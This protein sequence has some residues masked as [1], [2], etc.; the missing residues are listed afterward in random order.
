MILRQFY[1]GCLSQASYLVADE[2]SGRAAVVDP[3][4]DVQEYLEAAGEHGLRIELVVLTHVHADFVPGHTELAERTGAEIAMGELAPVEFPVRRLRDGEVIT[5]GDPASGV[6]IEVLS[7]PGHTPES[8]TLAVR[9]RASDAAPSALLTGDTLF[10]GDVGRPD[11]LGAAGRTPQH[12]ARDLYRSIQEKIL[13]LPDSVRI[14]PGH[15]AGSAC[16]KALSTETVS[17]L[18]EQRVTNYALASMSE[19]E[20]VAA[21][22]D[23]LAEPPAYFAEEV[24][25]NRAG[26]RSFDPSAA[27]PELELASALEQAR[28]GAL[29]LDVRDDQ[30]FA[31]GHPRG[32]VNVGL[33]G[34]FAE[35][36]AAVHESGQPV[37]LIGSPADV[38]EARLRLARV[39][40][41]TIVGALT[42]LHTL[43]AH[44]ELTSTASRLTA[45]QAAGRIAE[46]PGLQVVDVRGPGE[47]A[48]GALAG[49]LNLP[50]PRLRTQ[51]DRLDPA[52]PV[53]VNCAGGY[54]S[55]AAASLLRA[56]GFTDVSDLLG[57]WSAY[58]AET[59]TSAL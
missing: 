30:T 45:R 15:G 44:P 53:L 46:L 36:A 59:D 33:S 23:G 19:D 21:V 7:T 11:L 26:H 52:R 28:L 51:L 49:A 57:G 12:M 32:A 5:L 56:H 48:G 54:R 20:F 43:P 1:L 8:I 4:R 25:V 10:L 42:Q 13:P 31:A 2:S 24:A 3:R 41:D 50:L 58:T 47:F 9:E 35:Y 27:L 34:R 16:G 40:I 17:T 39:G 14:Y 37:V 18:G 38:R 55:S 29:L 6:S 22:T